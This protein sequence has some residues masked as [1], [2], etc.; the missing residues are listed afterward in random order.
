MGSIRHSHLHSWDMVDMRRQKYGG[1]IAGECCGQNVMIMKCQ[2][3]QGSMEG[4]GPLK[5]VR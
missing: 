5:A 2:S 1:S 3:M 4:H